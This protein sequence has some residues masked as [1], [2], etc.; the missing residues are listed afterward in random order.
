MFDKNFNIIVGDRASGRTNL[1]IE[2]SS[3]LKSVGYKL[4]FIGG[5]TEL[6]DSFNNNKIYDISRFAKTDDHWDTLMMKSIK[7]ITERDKYDYIIVDD[8]EYLTKN[9][10][11]VLDTISVRKIVTSLTDNIPDIREK[12]LYE[13]VFP[14]NKW[15]NIKLRINDGEI[16]PSDIIKTLTRDKKIKSIL[17]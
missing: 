1:L 7:E 16:S 5:T 12:N 11:S 6:K 8:L 2:I 9:C 4:C 15:G 13:I 3:A 14:E 10:L 17:K